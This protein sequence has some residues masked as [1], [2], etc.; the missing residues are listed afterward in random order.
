MLTKEAINEF[1]QIFL[2]EYGA[3]LSDDEATQKATHLFN[4]F[5]V[6]A[7]PTKKVDLQG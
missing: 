2:K 7:T 3:E 4:L 5:V 1:K 6:L